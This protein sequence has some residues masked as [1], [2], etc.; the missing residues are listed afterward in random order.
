[1]L[2]RNFDVPPLARLLQASVLIA[3]ATGSLVLAIHTEI[4][5]PRIATEMTGSNTI[6]V[7]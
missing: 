1:M 6:V 3:F 5:T 2:R 4:G 7:P